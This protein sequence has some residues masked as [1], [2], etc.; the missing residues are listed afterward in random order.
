VGDTPIT[1]LAQVLETAG[2]PYALIGGH[3]VN[4]WLEPRFT[5]DLDVTVQAGPS[6][7]ARLTDAL[8][9]K[10]YTRE[11]IHGAEQSSGPDFARFVSSTDGVVLEVQ[12][13]KTAFQREAIERARVSD[14]GV[15]VATI[16]DLIVMKLIADR[17]K[18][19]VDLLGLAA[20]PD[21]DWAYVERWAAEWGV[22]DR[23]RR[24][25]ERMR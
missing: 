8:V 13:A 9:Q 2:V 24:L 5:A 4:V 12:V 15:R 10:G 23:L 22:A 1:A 16:E 20:L 19:Q 6:E 25:R 21:L 7:I 17:A 14:D 3:A 11:R 18:D